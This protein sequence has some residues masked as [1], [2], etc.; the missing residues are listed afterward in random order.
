MPRTNV[1]YL[2]CSW[3]SAATYDFLVVE[4]GDVGTVEPGEGIFDRRSIG[5]FKKKM[6]CE[7]GK[8]DRNFCFKL[9]TDSSKSCERKMMHLEFASCETRSLTMV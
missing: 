4:L 5:N 6:S 8:T 2:Q 3:I 7:D 1:S 9:K